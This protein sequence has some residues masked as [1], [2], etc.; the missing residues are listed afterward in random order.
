M[1]QAKDMAE[2]H[3][4]ITAR[5][6]DSFVEPLH[7]PR[8]AG[9]E[10]HRS[11]RALRALSRP[12]SISAFR[13]YRSLTKSKSDRRPVLLSGPEKRNI[14]RDPGWAYFEPGG[15]MPFMRRYSTICP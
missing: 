2:Q 8:V 4:E 15:T 7:S 14:G 13:P 10:S 12:I 11:N 1:P 6:E 9:I 5:N 3:G